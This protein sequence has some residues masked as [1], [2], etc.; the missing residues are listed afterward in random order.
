MPRKRP[1]SI[2]FSGKRVLVTG[3]SRGIAAQIARDFLANGACVAVNFARAADAEAGYPDAADR[4]VEEAKANRGKAVSIEANL[5][6][7]D[8]AS[9]LIDRAVLS[10]GGLDILVLSASLQINKPILDQVESEI[11]LQLQLNLVSNILMIQ[12]AIRIM[13]AQAWGR[14]IT[15]G[16]IQEI[17]PSA[18]MP[19]YAMTK[20][21]LFNLVCNLAVQTA[22]FGIT[23]NNIA[24]GLIHTDRNAHRRIDMKSWETL[25]ANANPIRRAGRPDEVSGAALY[26]ASDAASFTTGAN[27]LITGGGHIAVNRADGPAGR[28]S[29]IATAE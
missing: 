14:I 1:I 28:L 20:A 25:S 24:P 13:R 18:E 9:D 21:A 3:G 15:I 16:S 5:A 11:A 6:D 7:P 10:L 19:I 26:L 4:L 23:V 17:A 27:I 2:D 22:P 29:D 12:K 8:E